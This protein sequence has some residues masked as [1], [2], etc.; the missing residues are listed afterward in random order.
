MRPTFI[1]A[2][3]L[4]AFG[5]FF[6][7]LGPT[8]LGLFEVDP[9][10]VTNPVDSSLATELTEAGSDAETNPIGGTSTG[11]NIIDVLFGGLLN[12]LYIIPIADK[13]GIPLVISAAV[14][15]ILALVYVIDLGL[16]IRGLTQ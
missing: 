10:P 16:W 9:L 1:I 13:L 8:G 2:I 5:L 3:F 11:F 6:N 15:A 14:N 12:V 7:M 4:L